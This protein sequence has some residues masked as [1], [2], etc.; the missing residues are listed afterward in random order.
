MFIGIQNRVPLVVLAACLLCAPVLLRAAAPAL[1]ESV[2]SDK[3]IVSGASGQL[4]RLVV[5][6]LLARGVPAKNLILVS[7]TPQSLQEFEKLGAST[8]FG[9]F[10]KPE[11]LPAAFA[12]GTRMLL[13]SI[14]FG[15]PPR[16]EAHKQAIDAAVNAG[17]KQIAY[18]SWVAISGGDSSGIGA[19]HFQTEETLKKSGVAWT[20][21]R[22]SIYQDVLIAQA[23]K[24]IAEGRAVVPAHEVKL[25]YVARED[26]AAAAA[27]VLASPGHEN[28]AYDITGSELIGQREIAA[29]A[30]AVTGKQISVVDADPAAPAARAFAGPAASRVSTAVADLT[31][32]PPIGLRALFEA[33]KAALL[34]ASSAP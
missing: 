8:R 18:T 34:G 27:A 12:G 9:D 29:A 3:I 19:D 16:P 20:M 31:G 2:V 4:G 6:Q 22:N 21:L 15:G 7:R 13:I 14:G 28:R 11:S 17:V 5:K 1:K 26:C 32:R 10:G 23:A 24:M 33:N 25:G 30:S